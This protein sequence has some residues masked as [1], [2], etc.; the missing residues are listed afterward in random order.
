MVS[1]VRNPKRERKERAF[2]K[3]ER[4]ELNAKPWLEILVAS[5]LL[6]PEEPDSVERKVTASLSVADFNS[7]KILA[8]E[9]G[10]QEKALQYCI[11]FTLAQKGI[12]SEQTKPE[13]WFVHQP[14]S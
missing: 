14:K 3:T 13:L 6:P 12:K 8:A 1:L 4:E 5:F 9:L 10:S 7:F 11:R 2:W